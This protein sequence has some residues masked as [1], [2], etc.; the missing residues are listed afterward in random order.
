[1][2]RVI[3]AVVMA[4]ALSAQAAPSLQ[5]GVVPTGSPQPSSAS[6]DVKPGATC[7]SSVSSVA[8]FPVT[9]TP[10]AVTGGS[11]VT[12]DLTKLTVGTYCLLVTYVY[13]NTCT[14]GATSGSCSGGTSVAT[15]F[16]YTEQPAAAPSG[17]SLSPQ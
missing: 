14:S 17:L 6:L 13:P 8:G 11:Q 15:P 1:M 10:A 7:P 3:A 5:A 16:T 4:A 12:F 2:K 9:A